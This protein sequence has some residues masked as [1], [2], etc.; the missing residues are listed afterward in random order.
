MLANETRSGQGR[1]Q[2]EARVAQHAG[3]AAADYADEMSS[4]VSVAAAF[5]RL[6]PQDAEA[7]RLVAWEN[8]RGENPSTKEA[9][10][11]A[12]CSRPAFVVPLHR[13][14]AARARAQCGSYA[15][16]RLE[17]EI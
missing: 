15:A 3:S 1:S 14:G 16:G 6:S 11:A 5:Q 13:P 17:G 9:A 12:G 10:R 8:L 2:L 4:R 7:L